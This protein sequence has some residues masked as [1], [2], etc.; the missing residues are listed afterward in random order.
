MLIRLIAILKQEKERTVN[1]MIAGSIDTIIEYKELLARYRTLDE[2]IDMAS[3]LQEDEEA[4][5]EEDD[6]R[7]V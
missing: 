5:E 2:V 6:L 3:K 1:H 7:D 4:F